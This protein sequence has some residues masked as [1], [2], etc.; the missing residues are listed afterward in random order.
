MLTP[1]DPIVSPQ[2]IAKEKK[3][4]KK[5]AV[6]VYHLLASEVPSDVWGVQVSYSYNI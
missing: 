1:A 5:P 2:P 4:V 6:H 3:P